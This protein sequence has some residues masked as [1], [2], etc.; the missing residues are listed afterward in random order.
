MYS[1]QKLDTKTFHQKRKKKQQWQ[2]DNKIT[3]KN[4]CYCVNVCKF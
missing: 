2:Q 4:V 1:A 3:C